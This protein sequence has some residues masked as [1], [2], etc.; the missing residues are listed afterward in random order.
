MKCHIQCELFDKQIRLK[1]CW[2]WQSTNTP[3]KWNLKNPV[4]KYGNLYHIHI[5]L[6][7]ENMAVFSINIS[8]FV[9]NSYVNRLESERR[10]SCIYDKILYHF[11]SINFLVKIQYHFLSRFLIQRYKFRCLDLKVNSKKGP[12]IHSRAAKIG[13]SAPYFRHWVRD[14]FVF[15]FHLVIKIKATK[16]TVFTLVY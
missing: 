15:F 12:Q 1:L 8:I 10:N 3:S 9:F 14:C 6:I 5:D 4:K 11:L 16:T 7:T 13:T 2:F